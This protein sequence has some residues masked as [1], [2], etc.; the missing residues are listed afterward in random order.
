MTPSPRS[1]PDAPP[2]CPKCKGTGFILSTADDG[3][4]Y[5]SPCECRDLMIMHNKLR[6]AGIPPKFEGCTVESFDLSLYRSPDSREKAKMAK[7]LCANYVKFFPQIQADGKGLYL[8]SQTKGSGKTR[9][10]ASVANDIMKSHRISARFTTSLQILDEIK[11]T[12]KHE[13]EYGSEQEFLQDIIDVPLLVIDDVGVERETPWIDEKFNSILNGRMNAKKATIFTSNCRM[14]NLGL[15]ERIIS[16]IIG[17]SLPV[18]FPDE[19]VRSQLARTE[20]K[21]LYKMLLEGGG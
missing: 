19:S 2:K 9:M 6:F 5:A 1:E 11:K 14:E 18:P 17:M 13:A 20:N 15:D 7:K 8:Y 3:R 16:R 21:A 12:W 4:E 10:A